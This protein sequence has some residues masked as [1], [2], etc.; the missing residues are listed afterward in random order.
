MEKSSG[1][2]NAAL[3]GPYDHTGVEDVVNGDDGR[4]GIGNGTCG[5]GC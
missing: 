5:E 4:R 2:Y 1:Q 3:S